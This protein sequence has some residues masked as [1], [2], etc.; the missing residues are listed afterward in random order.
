MVHILATLRH[1]DNK[2]PVQGDL[3][4]LIPCERRLEKTE[5]PEFQEVDFRTRFGNR[6]YGRPYAHILVTLSGFDNFTV[7]CHN[8]EVLLV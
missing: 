8:S 4:S 3:G 1:F 5:I 7:K 2:V 6:D